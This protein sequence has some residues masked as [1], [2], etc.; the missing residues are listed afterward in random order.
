M[1]TEGSL[2]DEAWQLSPSVALR[3]ES[4]GALAYHFGNRKLIFLK[5]P[6]LV[7]VVRSLE[8]HDDVRS[9][10]IQADV[11]EGLWPAYESALRQLAAADMIRPGVG[12][13]TPPPA[14]PGGRPTGG[15]LAEQFE[16]GLDAPICLTWELTYACNL[17]CVHCLSSSGRRDP[18]E[19]TTAQCEAVIGEL[20]RM[21]VFYVNIGGGEPTIQ[22]DFWHLLEYAVDHH[23]GVKFSTNGVRITPERARFLASTDYVDVQVSLDGATAAV[24]D[25]IRGPGSYEMAVR[26]LGNLAEAGF[27]DA[28]LS[29]VVTRCNIGQLDEFRTLADRFGAV[30]RLTRL[31]PSGRGAEVWDRLHPLPEQQRVLYD[32]LVA[33]GEGVLTGDSFFH[34]AAFGETLPGLNLCGAGRVVCLIDPV[35]DVYACPFAIHDSFLAGN[36]LT[37]GG[38]GRVWQTS[39]LFKELRF[40]QTSG[41]CTSCQFFSSCRGGC[42]AAKFFTGLP[43]DGPDPECV[44][45]H[46]QA[47]L[48]GARSV[49]APS[50]DHSRRTP[51]PNQPVLLQLGQREDLA[52]APVPACADHP[53]AG[54]RA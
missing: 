6:E 44:R 9:A 5:R 15:S 40:P 11:A 3:P 31:R 29:V 33:H 12:N 54:F 28:K 24:N 8:R 38:F 49:P 45:G 34:L 46:G 23:V 30:L 26:A 2:L 22:A 13:G 16:Y 52:A 32:W 4:F 27:R 42:M 20:Q 1:T 14:L 48:A 47:A 19:L 43:V 17:A 10:L 51:V 53:L 36:V 41:A 37:D 35:G 7:S 39:E 18:R 25:Y 50:R 21:Q